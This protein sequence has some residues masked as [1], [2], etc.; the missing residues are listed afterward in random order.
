MRGRNEPVPGTGEEALRRGREGSQTQCDVGNFHAQE[1]IRLAR[2]RLEYLCQCSS[3]GN[4][5]AVWRWS[6]RRRLE[7]GEDGILALGYK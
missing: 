6:I 3:A 1:R 5:A 2:L 7:K 4:V